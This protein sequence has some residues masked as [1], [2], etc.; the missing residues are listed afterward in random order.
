MEITVGVSRAICG[1]E[2]VGTVKIG[3][4]YRH[5][6]DLHRPLGKL[7]AGRSGKRCGGFFCFVPKRLYLHAGTAAGKLLF[8]RF[9]CRQNGGFVVGRC[10]PLLEGDRVHGTSRQAIPQTIAIVLS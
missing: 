2:K 7:T 8:L 1:D 4:V 6:A 10:F 9:L 3:R 5:K